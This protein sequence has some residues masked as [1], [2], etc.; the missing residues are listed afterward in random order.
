[1]SGHAF[2]LVLWRHL[3]TG[4]YQL[5]SNFE[6]FQPK[7]PICFTAK[8]VRFSGAGRPFNTAYLLSCKNFDTLMMDERNNGS[9]KVFRRVCRSS[10][11]SLGPSKASKSLFENSN[12]RILQTT[13]MYAKW[14]DIFTSRRRGDKV[15]WNVKFIINQW[16]RSTIPEV[17]NLYGI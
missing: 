4:R 14:C 10:R 16:H 8:S 17:D 3:S 11:R 15:K 9:V 13:D 12:F 2:L 6:N 7:V 5:T 1:M